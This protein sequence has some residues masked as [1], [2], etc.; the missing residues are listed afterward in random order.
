[1]KSDK[2]K[3]LTYLSVLIG[4]FWCGSLLLAGYTVLTSTETWLLLLTMAILVSGVY[5]LWCNPRRL[6]LPFLEDMVIPTGFFPTQDVA[7][8]DA[9]RR[10]RIR[11]L[12]PGSRVVYWAADPAL[13]PCGIFPDPM[14]AYRGGN[15]RGI[16][17][18]DD[19]GEAVLALRY[20]GSY[21]VPYRG[22][23]PPHCHLR[24][25]HPRDPQWLSRIRTYDFPPTAAAPPT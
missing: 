17:T 15:N 20:P 11:N 19:K 13:T 7:P 16:A 2:S 25:F 3:E 21:I 24:V 6:F 14:T 5:L 8:P 4:F 22:L 9:D 1:M 10:V 23:L 12:R 18:A